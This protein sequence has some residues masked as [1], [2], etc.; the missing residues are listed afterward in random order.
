MS[1]AYHAQA[2]AVVLEIEKFGVR[3]FAHK[4]D[5][6]S[7]DQVAAMFV[8]MFKQ[9]GTIDILVNNAGLQRDSKFSI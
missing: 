8:R 7:A 4:A 3:A 2:D 6:S 5:V 9:F 1:K